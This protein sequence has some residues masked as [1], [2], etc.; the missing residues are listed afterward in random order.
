MY[1]E[2]A[3]AKLM[4]LDPVG[5]NGLFA[6]LTTEDNPLAARA[7]MDNTL[8]ADTQPARSPSYTHKDWDL[9]LDQ[10]NSDTKTVSKRYYYSRPSCNWSNMSPRKLLK[11]LRS[12]VICGQRISRI[13]FG[14][15]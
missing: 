8:F 7:T 12:G 10:A 3:L 9:G 13:R 1:V 15:G 2:S 5:Y 4:V 14:L 6:T 11:F